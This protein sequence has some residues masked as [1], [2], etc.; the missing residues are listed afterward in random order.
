MYQKHKV[1]ISLLFIIVFSLI[2]IF[3]IIQLKEETIHSIITFLS[4]TFGFYMTSLSVLY[5][6]NYSKELFKKIDLKKKTQRKAHT[7]I[8]YFKS[9]SYCSLISILVFLL[10]M[11]IELNGNSVLKNIWVKS[12]LFSLLSI[13]VMFIFL[14]FKIFTV[15]FIHESSK[16]NLNQQ[17]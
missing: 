17:K 6:S 12:A 8:A 15:G 10:S 5:R 1:Y 7:L 2:R 3:P 14:L 11:S 13:N 16:E 9:A 4:I